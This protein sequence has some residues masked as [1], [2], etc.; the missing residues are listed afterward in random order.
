[1]PIVFEAKHSLL[2]VLECRRVSRRDGGHTYGD[3]QAFANQL[4]RLLVR[5]GRT[6]AY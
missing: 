3:R 4:D 1:M 6:G 2:V 5:H